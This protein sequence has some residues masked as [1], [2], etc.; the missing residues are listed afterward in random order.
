MGD[1]DEIHQIVYTSK[2]TRPM[3][4]EDLE[5]ILRTARPRNL[6]VGITGILL[7][8]HGHFLQVLEGPNEQLNV[9][10]DR[11]NRDPRHDSVRVLLEGYVLSRAFGAWSMAFQDVSGLDPSAVPGYSKF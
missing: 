5:Q 9:L 10:L 4:S 7:Y 11:L 6:A 2:A 3:L 8:R 1:M